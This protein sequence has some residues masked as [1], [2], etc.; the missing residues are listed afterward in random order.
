MP[1]VEWANLKAHELRTLSEQDAIVIV[2]VGSTEQHGPHMP[3]QTDARLASEV[4]QRT[5]HQIADRA[6]VVVTPTVWS[7]L[8]EH[9]MSLGGTITL[10]FDTFSRLL[11][12]IV[13]SLARHGFRRILLL[14]GHGGNIAA[15]DLIVGELTRELAIPL[16]SVNYWMV[17]PDVVEEVLERQ[18]ALH[19]ACEG[20]TSLMLAVAPELVDTD[21][22]GE[23][24]GRQDG[25]PKTA[26]GPGMGRWL[27][28]AE[29]TDSGVIGDAALASAEK[30]RVLIEAMVERLA[31][32]LTQPDFWTGPARAAP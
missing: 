21:R 13:G 10:D 9:H 23:A 25:D 11:R 6:P 32:K 14:N 4:A 18:T 26:L 28:F 16:T 29:R 22:L 20:E 7:G 31:E 2:P 30:G 3:V 12:G 1:D 27:P 24:H 5:A 17:A 19:H 15:L 8:A